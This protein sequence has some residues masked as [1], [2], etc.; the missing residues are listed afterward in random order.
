MYAVHA[1]PIFGVLT[2]P[3]FNYTRELEMFLTFAVVLLPQDASY[4][5]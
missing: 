1:T 4:N 2:T 5:L 3:T